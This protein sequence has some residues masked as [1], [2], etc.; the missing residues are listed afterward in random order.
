MIR[1]VLRPGPVARALRNCIWP[2]PSRG[3]SPWSARPISRP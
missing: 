1:P 2:R 3:E